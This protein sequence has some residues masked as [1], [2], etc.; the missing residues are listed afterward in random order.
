MSATCGLVVLISGN[1]SNLQALIDDTKSG[2]NPAR[3]HAVVSDQA[4]A[5]GLQRAEQAGIPTRILPPKNYPDRQSFDQALLETVE[6][7]QPQLVVLAGFMRI[8]GA[9]FVDHFHGRLLNIHPS[10]LPRHKGLHTH[11]QALQAGDK[12]HG[13]SVHFVT[14]ELDGGPLV[15]QVRVPVQPGDDEASLAQRVLIQEHR[16]YPL[17]IRWFAEGRLNLGDQGPLLDGQP[18]PDGGPMLDQHDGGVAR[19]TGR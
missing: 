15:A 14:R 12:E 10:L 11:R 17:V 2:A 5:F 4:Q 9:T 3:I 16:L 8:L 7:Y 19:K 18:I 6:S 1:G 13:C